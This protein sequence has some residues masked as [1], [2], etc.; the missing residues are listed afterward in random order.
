MLACATSAW[1]NLGIGWAGTQVSMSPGLIPI[2][3][4]AGVWQVTSWLP[5]FRV[6]LPRVSCARIIRSGT[7]VR[8]RI[9]LHHELV[10]PGRFC[11][12]QAGWCSE[13]VRHVLFPTH[14]PGFLSE[15]IRCSVFSLPVKCRSGKCKCDFS[16]AFPAA[17]PHARFLSFFPRVLS[18]HNCLFRRTRFSACHD[19]AVFIKC[20]G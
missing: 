16:S 3:R 2:L 9:R 19:S 4:P 20:S 14:G 13:G 7:M 18:H 8:N 15:Y 10:L 6:Q 17:L 11:L 1:A 5:T 12:E